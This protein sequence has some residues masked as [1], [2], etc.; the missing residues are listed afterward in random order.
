MTSRRGIYL[1]TVAASLAAR[2]VM[3]S[4]RRWQAA[5]AR[6]ACRSTCARQHRRYTAKPQHKL[7]KEIP[8]VLS[9]ENKTAVRC[10]NTSLFD[11]LGLPVVAPE[12]HGA[13]SS[14]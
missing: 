1:P 13:G 11:H 10:H 7:K 5:G 9:G 14:V 2:L 3:V 6:A 4:L 8:T 12:C